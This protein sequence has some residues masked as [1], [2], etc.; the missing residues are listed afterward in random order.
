MADHVELATYAMVAQTG[1][2]TPGLLSMAVDVHKHASKNGI[3]NDVTAEVHE[4]VTNSN[5]MAAGG[6]PN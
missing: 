4:R 1:I 2:N 5:L 6:N 3:L